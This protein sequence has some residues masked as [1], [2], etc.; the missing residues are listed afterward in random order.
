MSNER[1][2]KTELPPQLAQIMDQCEAFIYSTRWLLLFVNVG[3]VA[4]LVVYLGRFA[5]DDF[6]VIS[7][8]LTRSTE[9]VR[10]LLLGLVDTALVANLMVMI[11]Q[12]SH[13]IFIRR[14]HVHAQDRPQWLDH[15]DSGILKVKVALSIAGITL[16]QILKDFVHLE[17]VSWE[18]VVRRMI[19]H[20]M[21]LVSALVMAIIWRVTHTPD[22][23]PS[24]HGV[25]KAPDITPEKGPEP[26][27]AK[28]DMDETS[29]TT[30]TGVHLDLH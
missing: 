8:G 22:S 25:E 19:V 10:V 14:F 6:N 12:G 11:I 26:A 28:N 24:G 18:V 9:D 20:A 21:C 7:T 3:L 17:E 23:S 29:G 13:Q 4:A 27:E 16:I 5:A 30:T 15:I 1:K 2:I